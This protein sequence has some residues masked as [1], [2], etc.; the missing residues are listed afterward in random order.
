MEIGN[1]VVCITNV[2][3]P[4]LVEGQPYTI[5]LISADGDLVQVEGDE[6]FYCAWRFAPEMPAD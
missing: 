4:S 1:T 6:E 3:C 2:S 5:G